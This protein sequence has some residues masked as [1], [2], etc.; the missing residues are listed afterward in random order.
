MILEE[1]TKQEFKKYA[2][3][4]P[5][6]TFH[7]TVEWGNLKEHQ[8]W[9]AHY[10]GLRKEGTIV[11]LS[12]LLSK[13]T[14]LKFNMFYAPRGFL[15]DYHDFSLLKEFTKG[16]K[17]YVKKNKGI[18]MKIDPYVMYQERDNLG[19]IVENGKENKIVVDNLKSLGYRHFGFNI[20]QEA[21]QPRWMHTLTVKGK[22]VDE[23]LKETDSKTR[24]I[25]RKNEKCAIITREI[26]KDELETFKKVMQHT[27]DRRDFI[28][29]PLSYYQSMWDNLHD[30][31]ILKVLLAEIHFDIYL[32]NVEN[33]KNALKDEMETR[34][35]KHDENP[36]KM[37]E[38]K[39]LQ[40][41]KEDSDEIARLEKKIVEI[42]ELKDTH[43]KVVVLGGIL[44]LIYGN[45]VLSLNGGS[46]KE[47]MQFQSAYTLHWEMI[48]Y[49]A[50]H[51]FDTYN[52]YGITGDFSESNPLY[53]L[54][55]FKRGFGGQVTELIGEFDLIINKPFYY[56]Y[57]LAFSSYKK[58]KNLR[59]RLST[60]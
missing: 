59:H 28:D 12:L 42:K 48:K 26:E 57:K 56:L 49:A 34:Q 53:G 11:A 21:L 44:F 27:S 5:Y 23:L 54:Y 9:R 2:D 60:K 40:K 16:I 47:L 22:N 45:E 43:G 50:N 25:I 31:G 20:M 24:Q 33:E 1:L 18:F 3:K 8:G 13:K 19:N 17:E 6:I 39:F 10:V 15:I 7:Q 37:N 51:G 35:K 30:S 32:E 46:F 55:L 4:S 58:I 41:Q 36:S 14:P 52:F 38:K 29:R